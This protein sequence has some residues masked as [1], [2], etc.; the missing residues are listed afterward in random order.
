MPM[1]AATGL[2]IYAGSDELRVDRDARAKSAALCA[3][4]PMALETLDG[5]VD[6]VEQ[7]CDT[8]VRA[9]QVLQTPNLFSDTRVIWLKQANFLGDSTLGR[10]ESVKAKL[11]GL[12][13]VFKAGLPPATH[14]IISA[15]NFDRR[16]VFAK[17]CE[18]HGALVIH[19]VPEKERDAQ[20]FATGCLD[21]ALR[22]DGLR[23]TEDARILFLD[24]VA[25]DR[26]Q[27]ANE[28]EKL[29]LYIHP[30]KTI[31][32]DDV[33]QITS[34]TGEALRWDLVDSIGARQLPAL[35]TALERLLAQQEEPTALTAMIE[36]RFRELALYRDALDRQWVRVR[37]TT[38]AWGALP[39]D[40]ELLF[41]SWGKRDPRQAHPFAIAK[42][43]GQARNF[44][45]GELQH[46]LER[47]GDLYER[48]LSSQ[49]NR[50][51]GLE[52]LLIELVSRAPA[53][54]R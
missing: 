53:G 50:A 35:L 1:T 51:L 54:P 4:A 38:G 32:R 29:A 25:K 3:N 15:D 12:A 9:I 18:A 44:T 11:E 8:I 31:G 33:E 46:A 2:F 42:L 7:A 16:T 23:M 52:L 30:R 6:G 48:L 22:R 5:R 43:A 49:G 34:L 27:I 17:A 28:L 37:G 21:E 26:R 36:G 14:M 24:R 39:P 10:N 20:V 13:A 19:M 47:I 40:V 45:A 41:A